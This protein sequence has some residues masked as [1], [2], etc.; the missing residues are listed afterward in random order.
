MRSSWNFLKFNNAVP[1]GLFLL[2]GMGTAAF[3][4]TP[5]AQQAIYDTQEEVVSVDNSYIVNA[6]IANFDFKL[7]I[8]SITS[9]A[10][11]YYIAYSYSIIDLVD[12]VWKP[13]TVTDTLKYSKLEMQGQDLGLAVSRQLSQLISSKKSYLLS[14]QTHEKANGQTQKVVATEYSGLVGKFLDPSEQSFPGYVPVVDEAASASSSLQQLAALGLAQGEAANAAAAAHNA[15]TPAA[16]STPPTEAEIQ[17]LIQQRVNDMLAQQQLADEAAAQAAAAAAAN[18]PP[19]AAPPVVV[20]PPVVTP[21][22]V[23]IPPPVE[24]P[25]A[26]TTPPVETPPAT[27]TPPVTPPATT[28]PPVETPPA[29][30]PPTETPPAETPPAEAPPA[31]APP[32]TETQTTP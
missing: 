18:N 14:V 20:P 29:E 13:V 5:A 15:I 2:F 25:P 17:A 32:P 23:V 11:T 30:T 24:T 7:Q 9:D 27:T 22:P 8:T 19:P 4:A 6:D 28:T 1:I 16:S 10:T 3:A 26:T 12:Y 31:E 21:P